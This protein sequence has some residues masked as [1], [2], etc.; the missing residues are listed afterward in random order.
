[1]YV[2]ENCDQMHY[3]NYAFALLSFDDLYV[4][5]VLNINW[6]CASSGE[7]AHPRSLARAFATP[8]RNVRV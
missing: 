1:M 6:R 7:P 3:H 5:L 8:I 2:V 4:I